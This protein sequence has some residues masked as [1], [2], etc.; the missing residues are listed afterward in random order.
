MHGEVEEIQPHKQRDPADKQSAEER[1]RQLF[2]DQ[3]EYGNAEVERAECR[4]IP[5]VP[6]GI[7]PENAQAQIQ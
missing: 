5:A 4:H 1:A 6:D 3:I 2:P 7:K